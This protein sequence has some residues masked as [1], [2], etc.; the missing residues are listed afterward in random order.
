MCRQAAFLQGCFAR[1]HARAQGQ[2]KQ[3]RS[4]GKQTAFATQKAQNN[5]SLIEL[6]SCHFG[7][8]FDMI[9]AIELVS[10]RTVIRCLQNGP[11]LSVFLVFNL[12]WQRFLH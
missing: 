5:Q 2:A 12:V 6:R 1:S 8:Y 10:C 3:S 4:E 7:T 9:V 11:I